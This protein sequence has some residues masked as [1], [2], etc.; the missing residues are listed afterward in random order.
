MKIIST[1]PTRTEV[2]N[3]QVGDMVMNCFKQYKKVVEIY[4]EGYDVNGKAF[5]CFYQEFGT[6]EGTKMSHSIKEN[7][8][9][10]TI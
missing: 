10:I 3:L 9:I 2:E 4:G 7:E 5:K 6:N 8:Q 1:I